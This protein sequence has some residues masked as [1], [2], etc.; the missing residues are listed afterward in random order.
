MEKADGIYTIPGSFGWDDVGSWLALERINQT[1]ESGNY[2]SG[3]VISIDTERSIVCG[4]KRLIAM[5]GVEDIIV[6]DTDD[7]ILICSKDNTQD[8]KK[9]IENLKICNR[10]EL[11]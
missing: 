11:V 8:V 3:D 9:V 7:A 2:I 6:V 5:V 1:D 4:G 10:R